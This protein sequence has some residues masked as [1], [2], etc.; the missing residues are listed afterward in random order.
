MIIYLRP[1]NETSLYCT[2]LGVR[3]SDLNKVTSEN[4]DLKKKILTIPMSTKTWN[5]M[6]IPMDQIVLQNLRKYDKLPTLSATQYREYIKNI[7]ELAKL[8]RVIDSPV[9]GKRKLW[10]YVGTHIAK[11][12]FIMH[13]MDKGTG[14]RDIAVMTGTTTSEIQKTYGRRKPIEEIAKEW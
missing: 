5:E 11:K 12:T 7:C 2:V 14:Y 9:K 4:I 8:N 10:E 1:N 3:Y 6:V 13:A